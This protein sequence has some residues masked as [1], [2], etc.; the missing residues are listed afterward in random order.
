MCNIALETKTKQQEALKAYLEENASE[1]LADKINNGVKIEKDGK[2][3]LNKKTLDGFMNF[4]FEEAKKQ[5]EKGARG[6]MVEDEVVY[7]WLIH[8]FE[9]QDIIGTL[10]NEDGTEYKP[11]PKKTEEKQEKVVTPDAPPKKANTKKDNGVI[12]MFEGMD[13]IFTIKPDSDNEVEFEQVIEEKPVFEE[14]I[15]EEK[16]ETPKNPLDELKS[17]ILLFP[18]GDFLYIGFDN[19]I[20]YAGAMTNTGI[21]RQYEFEYEFDVSVDANVQDIYDYVLEKH[22]EYAIEKKVKPKTNP[23]YQKYLEAQNKYPNLVVILRVGDFY[24]IFGKDAIS[25]GNKLELT[26]T[27]RD[28]GDGTKTE[29]IGYPYHASD[30]YIDKITKDFSVV[31]IEADGTEN[32]I[33]NGIKVDVKTGEVI[34]EDFDFDIEIVAK[35]YD[36]FGADMEGC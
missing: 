16:I 2:T 14:P 31:V 10:Y 19:G 8:Y 6:T 33:D 11:T 3:L 1:T 25:V 9:E 7:G 22:P 35:L 4:A 20:I 32:V 30:V 13:D 34:D 18:S 27:S 5:A 21:L 15:V 17:N 28:K 24:E 23:I 36:I 26:I 29:M 12:S